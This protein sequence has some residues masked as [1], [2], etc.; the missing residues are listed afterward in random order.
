M[1]LPDLTTP[2]R[3]GFVV[4]CPACVLAGG[5]FPTEPEALRLAGTHDDTIHAGHPTADVREH[6]AR[7]VVCGDPIGI[8]D[9]GTWRETGTC[10]LPAGH[11]CPCPDGAWPRPG[12]AVAVAS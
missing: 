3:G 7:V 1:S 2:T 11:T 9:S 8:W 5:P 12:T 4:D 6:P 10:P